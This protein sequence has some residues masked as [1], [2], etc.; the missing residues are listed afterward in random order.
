MVHIVNVPQ[1]FMIVL[2]NVV[3]GDAYIDDC[4][5][6]DDIVENDNETCT[7]CTDEIAENYD[8]HATISCDDCCEYAPLSFDLLT[9]VDDSRA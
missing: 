5:I 6:R 8:E 3:H 1:I 4:G 9:P 2:V 7:G